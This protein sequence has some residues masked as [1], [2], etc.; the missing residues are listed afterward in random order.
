MGPAVFL[1][2]AAYSGCHRIMAVCFFIIGMA[3]TS[4]YF[5]GT[6]I[7]TLEFAPNFSGT[8]MGFMNTFNFI[9]VLILPKVAA[10]VSSK[11][12]TD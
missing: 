12:R 7:N 8:V 4:F 9:P 5:S 10:S 6:R 2:A 11:V 1:L 3:L